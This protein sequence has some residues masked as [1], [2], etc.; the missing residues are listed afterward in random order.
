MPSLPDWAPNLHPLVVHFPIGLLVAAALFDFLGLFAGPRPFLR[1]VAL[2]LYV[3]GAG[4]T[5][6]V[7]YSGM[8]AADSVFLPTE[9]NALLH[10]HSDLGAWTMWYFASY[11]L[12]RLA[13]SFGKAVRVS[14]IRFI[15]F[16]L[17][18]GGVGLMVYTAHRGAE[19]VFRHGV[20]IQALEDR[21][22][23]APAVADTARSSGGVAAGDSLWTW[24]PDRAAAWAP[25]FRW[26]VGSVATVDPALVADPVRGDVLA[27]NVADTVAFFVTPESFTGV[28]VDLEMD[29]S[30]FDGNVMVA[31]H[32]RDADTYAFSSVGTSGVRLGRSENGDLLIDGTGP[33]DGSAWRS[34]RMISDAGHFRTYVD[35][36]LASHAHAPGPAAGPVG[37]RFNGSGRVK[38]GRFAITS[39]R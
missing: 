36:E 8:Q 7:Y 37:L 21:P 4:A 12:I 3:I 23:V 25:S 9:A 20:G 17:G 18:L 30:G 16:V 1:Q 24:V 13:L 11:A 10:D 6:G 19:L 2:L 26:L 34:L 14:G 38:L 35:T 29:L 28:Q 5:F 32:V 39:L 31:Y 22:A 15:L 33:F 27:F